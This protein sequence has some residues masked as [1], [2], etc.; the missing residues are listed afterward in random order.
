MEY[1]SFVIAGN[2]PTMAGCN[3]G[4]V[5]FVELTMITRRTFGL[6][7]LV[8]LP[9]RVFAQPE[10]RQMMKTEGKNLRIYF[11]EDR[12]RFELLDKHQVIIER[13]D[14][15]KTFVLN[16]DSRTFSEKPYEPI[17]EGSIEFRLMRD[18]PNPD[19]PNILAFDS[20]LFEVPRNFKLVT[21]GH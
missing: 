13:I 9:S 7:V 4:V 12:R 15:K 2:F 17:V 16:L 6:M 11:A 10:A 21:E 14:L 1:W 5:G 20:K 3:E 8:M 19:H 18:T